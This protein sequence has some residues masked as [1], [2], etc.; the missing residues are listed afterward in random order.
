MTKRAT[1][2][3]QKR[4]LLWQLS[5]DDTRLDWR[6]KP[7]G[8]RR[9]MEMYFADKPTNDWQVEGNLPLICFPL[10]ASWRNGL[11]FS[12]GSAGRSGD[13]VWSASNVPGWFSAFFQRAAELNE[14]F[15]GQLKRNTCAGR[16]AAVAVRF[17]SFCQRCVYDFDGKRRSALY[18]PIRQLIKMEKCE[19]LDILW[20]ICLKLSGLAWTCFTAGDKPW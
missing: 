8:N 10:R 18:E 4:L 7:L 16:P 11:V 12:S 2:Q 15:I 13:A 6:G 5:P 17:T 1:V 20:Q 9:S 3:E 14:H 19:L